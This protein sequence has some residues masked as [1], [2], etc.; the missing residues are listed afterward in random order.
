MVCHRRQRRQHSPKLPHLWPTFATPLLTSTQCRQILRWLAHLCGWL[1]HLCGF[2]KG[3][4]QCGLRRDFP[5][6]TADLIAP[7]FTRNVKVGQPPKEIL[8]G[9]LSGW[10]MADFLG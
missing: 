5:P 9:L 8:L 6:V 3:G 10:G 2:C 1:A 7:T 4:N